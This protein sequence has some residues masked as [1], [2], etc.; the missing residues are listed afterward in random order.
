MSEA[1]TP[2]TAADPDAVP[3]VNAHDEVCAGAESTDPPEV[4]ANADPAMEPLPA[5]DADT[6]AGTDTWSATG[7]NGGK[8]M[9]R[10]LRSHRTFPRFDGQRGLATS[11]QLRSN[12]WTGDA[13]RHARGRSIQEIYPGVFAPHLGPIN[14]DDRLVGASLWAGEFAVLTGRV[15]LDRHGLTVPSRDTC[16]FLVPNSQ[17]NRQTGGVR[18]VRTTRPIQV[19]AY[20]DCVAITDIAR[21][22]CDAALYQQLR[23]TELQALT[24][25]ALQQRRTHPQLVQEA[26]VRQPVG[27]VRGI[28]RGLETFTDGAWS[29]PEGSLGVLVNSDQELPEYLMNVVLRSVDGTWI[30]CPDGYFREAGVAAQVH[31]QT[32]H[33]GVD[34]QGRDRWTATVEKDA[35]FIENGIIVVPITPSSIAKR[36][37]QVLAR[38]RRVVADNMGR[39]MSHIVIH[40][41]DQAGGERGW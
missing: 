10:P 25:A 14:P 27:A 32:F 35:P 8:T 7:N 21:A 23:G 24:I 31:S 39:D 2:G 38:L 37:K 13:I 11:A 22:L 12:G 30:G 16:L 34:D 4:Q 26:L 33:S 40:E 9:L 15:A 6:A 28:S 20:R 18:T 19:A 29:M 36:P 41:R 1:P 3:T 17:R 5:V